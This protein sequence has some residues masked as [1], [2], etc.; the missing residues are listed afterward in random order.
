[1]KKYIIIA[2]CVTFGLRTN[3]QTDSAKVKLAELNNKMA[4]RVGDSLNLTL[5][6]VD[7]IRIINKGLAEKKVV[8][9]RTGLDS[10]TLQREIQAVE[11]MR[12]SLYKTVLSQSLYFEYM[13]RKNEIISNN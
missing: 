6:A 2:A 12:D 13:R 4:K 9:W 3:A 1:M 11:N 5:N 7:S 8:I 10:K